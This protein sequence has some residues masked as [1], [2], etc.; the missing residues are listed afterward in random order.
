MREQYYMN[1]NTGEITESH[2]TAVLEWYAKGD[3]VAVIVN[4]VARVTWEH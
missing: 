1:M 4:G 3:N 2:K